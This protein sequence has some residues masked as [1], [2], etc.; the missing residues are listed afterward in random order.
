MRLAGAS[1]A[2]QLACIDAHF[3]EK[4][5]DGY[6]LVGNNIRVAEHLVL[7]GNFTSAGTVRLQGARVDGIV[8]V[9]PSDL[10]GDPALDAIGMRVGQALIWKPQAQVKGLVNLGNVTTP[11][12][13]DDWGTDRAN[14]YWPKRIRLTGFAYESIGGEAQGNWKARRDWIRS[15]NATGTPFRPPGYDSQPYE[16]LARVYR[17]AGRD[18][19]A[20]NIAIARR[21]DLRRSGALNPLRKFFNAVYVLTALCAWAAQNHGNAIVPAKDTNNLKPPPTAARCVSEP[22]SS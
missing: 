11:G 8:L 13:V 4:D 16:H 22:L 7:K 15:N 2:G 18:D 12:L 20:R 17:Q 3:D 1:I 9:E 6:S 21:R 5:R 19:D 14:A 10:A